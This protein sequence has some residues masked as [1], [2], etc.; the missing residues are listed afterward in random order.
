[1]FNECIKSIDTILEQGKKVLE[2]INHDWKV[3]DD[4]IYKFVSDN[5]LIIS[6]ICLLCEGVKCSHLHV[7]YG[8]N[9]IVHA[10]NLSNTLASINIYT[11]LKGNIKNVD[12]LIDIEGR[13]YVQLYGMIDNMFSKMPV[14]KVNSTR[15]LPLEYEALSLFYK[16]YNPVYRNEWGSIEKYVDNVN[17]E[18]KT[19]HATHKIRQPNK[20]KYRIISTIMEWLRQRDDFILIGKY[21]L[22]ILNSDKS[23]TDDNIQIIASNITAELKNYMD[24]N[25]I[26][27]E[28]KIH[29]VKLP[30]DPRLKRIAVTTSINGRS[31]HIMDVFNANTHTLVPYTVMDNIKIG[32]KYV[33]YMYLFVDIWIINIIHSLRP[34]LNIYNEKIKKYYRLLAECTQLKHSRRSLSY[35]GVNDDLVVYKKKNKTEYPYYPEK[36]RYDKGKYRT[37]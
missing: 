37:I 26:L 9:I 31:E 34:I 25:K 6:D 16:L 23:K 30:I 24:K 12:Y 19:K 8:P 11:V 7:I 2:V 36:Y 21:A 20:I 5:K 17:K 4:A 14:V 35:L 1:M 10:N 28:F 22:K 3:I 27:L 13:P 33:L 18:I 15:L 29:S 32:S